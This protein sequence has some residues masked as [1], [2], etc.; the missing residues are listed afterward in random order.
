MTGI[1]RRYELVIPP[2]PTERVATA[3]ELAALRRVFDL[4]GVPAGDELRRQLQGLKV[5]TGCACGCAT[6]DLVPPVDVPASSVTV[7]EIR[8]NVLGEGQA[9]VGF[10]LVFLKAGRLDR[11]EFATVA[12]DP[13]TVVPAPESLEFAE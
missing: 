4:T 7:Q 10:L 11:L 13:I 6:V 2:D 1:K 5:R 3:E 9:F 8:A 12:E